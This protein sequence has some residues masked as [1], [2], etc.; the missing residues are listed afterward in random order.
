LGE[1]EAGQP[2]SLPGAALVGGNL[3]VFG[4]SGSGKS[5]VAGL[6]AEGMHR[7]GYQVV[8][9]DP[10]GDFRGLRGLPGVVVLEG[11][12]D[13]L[14]P[15]PFVAALLEKLSVSV[16]IDLCAYPVEH[17]E[18]YVAGL[19]HELHALRARVFR[20]HWIVMEEAHYFLPPH[21]NSASVELVSM[22]PDGGWAFVT[23]R[24]DRLCSPVLAALD[25]CLLTQMNDPEAVRTVRRWL[26][27]VEAPPSE[28][29][30]GHVLMGGR[31]LVRL[32][33]NARRIAH[34]RH[35]YQDL[36]TPLPPRKRFA[37]RDGHN[38]LGLEA[39]SL[40]EL[41]R[42]LPNLPADSLAYHQMRD[43][44]AAWAEVALGDEHLADQLHQ[45]TRR[46]LDGEPLRDALLQ[47]VAAH[48]AE[49]EAQ[50]APVA[51]RAYSPRPQHI[52]VVAT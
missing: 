39:A 15:P 20:P 27:G 41:L 17:R 23:Y 35:L 30:F 51:P 44:F 14:P 1:D 50:H 43:D 6:L 19:L 11:N 2:I 16:V 45:L 49:L 38:F 42:H 31:K 29:P 40:F 7:A 33:A 4:A 10:E 21:G 8:L 22:L 46:S 5:W 24:P 28:I 36:D 47:C 9:I 32:R 25:D 13:T 48:C 12:R 37:F 26:N 18:N 3:G 52:T 34:V